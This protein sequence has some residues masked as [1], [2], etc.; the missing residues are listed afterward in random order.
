MD[1]ARSVDL[2]S[3]AERQGFTTKRVGNYYTLKEHDSIRI[4]N[5]RTWLRFSVPQGMEGHSGD[6]IEFLRQFCGMDFR[7][8]VIYLLDEA[9]YG[10][11]D[12]AFKS[13]T[14][15]KKHECR[16]EGGICTSRGKR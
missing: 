15:R 13:D 8:S 9:G 7:E 3:I 11:V 12:K 10:Y 16:R 14:Y 2:V 5:R 1:I 6:T 4:K